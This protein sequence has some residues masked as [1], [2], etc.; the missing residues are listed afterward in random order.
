M[1]DTQGTVRSIPGPIASDTGQL[2]E[3]RLINLPTRFQGLGNLDSNTN[4]IEDIATQFANYASHERSAAEA[5][6]ESGLLPRTIT[7]TTHRAAN[8]EKIVQ[9]SITN[10]ATRAGTLSGDTT[11]ITYSNGTLTGFDPTNANTENSFGGIRFAAAPGNSKVILENHRRTENVADTFLATQA[12]G[13]LGAGIDNGSNQTSGLSELRSAGL[14]QDSGYVVPRVNDWIIWEIFGISGMR[15]EYNFWLARLVS[16]AYTFYRMNTIA[17]TTGGDQISTN[18]YHLQHDGTGIDIDRLILAEHNGYITHDNLPNIINVN[19][20]LWDLLR[21]ETRNVLTQ[22]RDMEFS[23]EVDFTGEVDFQN[24]TVKGISSTGGTPDD[25]SVGTDQLKDGAVTTDKIADDAVTADKIADGVIPAAV[26]TPIE[27][28]FSQNF[29]VAST[30]LLADT[31]ADLLASGDQTDRFTFILTDT[32]GTQTNLGSITRAEYGAAENLGNTANDGANQARAFVSKTVGN[33]TWYLM[34]MN[35]NILFGSSG[36]GT[37][38]GTFHLTILEASAGAHIYTQFNPSE[39]IAFSGDNTHSGTETF[40][41]TVNLTN[42]TITGLE[43]SDWTGR[44]SAG[45]LPQT[46]PSGWG[47]GSGG[48]PAAPVQ[49]HLGVANIVGSTT[50]IVSGA[51]RF[52]SL[53][54]NE[55]IRFDQNTAGTNIGTGI[56]YTS[57]NGNIVLPAGIWIL[58][59]SIRARMMG[60]SAP[61]ANTRSYFSVGI[62]HGTNLRHISAPAYARWTEGDK[63]TNVQ[64]FDTSNLPTGWGQVSSNIPAS[65]S[66]VVISSGSNQASNFVTVRAIWSNQLIAGA[67]VN[68]LNAHLHA[69]RLGAAS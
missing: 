33:Q 25:D 26:D 36:S 42:A 6:W 51:T 52:T 30:S 7:E 63:P 44:I 27:Q 18:A 40:S 43:A 59:A 49:L 47:T 37:R 65:V 11:G 56:I 8:W 20:N 16:N 32:A 57:T 68:L 60:N 38:I 41:G 50:G 13:R 35:R 5:Q 58:C 9:L 4:N 1:A 14:T 23:G 29:N 24:A 45:Q 10:R 28:I 22:E 66:G 12:N 21:T 15:V 69:V 3:A 55:A 34:H 19:Q 48:T 67:G 54:G 17:F 31:G 39:D 2:A 61:N 46:P 53:S 64:P 62:Q